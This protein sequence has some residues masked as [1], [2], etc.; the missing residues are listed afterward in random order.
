MFDEPELT[1]KLVRRLTS[2]RLRLRVLVDKAQL[3]LTTKT[4]QRCRS[5]LRQL[6]NAAANGQ[7]DA[8]VFLCR[9]REGQG[10][11]HLKDF[12]VDRRWYFTGSPNFTYAARRYNKE[13]MLLLTGSGVATV[14]EDLQTSAERGVLWDGASL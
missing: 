13:R 7:G 1:S 5:R 6:L 9:G 12:L 2:S 3:Q 10:S 8:Q 11:F 14:L 4:A